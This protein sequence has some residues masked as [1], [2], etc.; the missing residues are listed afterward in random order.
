[1][2]TYV[3]GVSV[4]DSLC[5][6]GRVS[7]YDSLCVSGRVSVC[8]SFCVSG[9]VS[10]ALFVSLVVSLLPLNVYWWTQMRVKCQTLL[11]CPCVGEFH[12]NLRRRWHFDFL[13]LEERRKWEKRG[14]GRNKGRYKEW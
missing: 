4:Y 3:A 10:V 5:V 2:R 14:S 12:Q 7:V 1:M 9:G 13:C 6:S 11:T 8:G